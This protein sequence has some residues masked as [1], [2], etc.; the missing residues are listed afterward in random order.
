MKQSTKELILLMNKLKRQSQTP[1]YT[2]MKAEKLAD[3][4]LKNV[5][6]GKSSISVFMKWDRQG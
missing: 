2:P 4:V 5:A 3:A 6:G 1:N